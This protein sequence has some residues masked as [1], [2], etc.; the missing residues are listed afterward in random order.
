MVLGDVEETITVVEMDEETYE[1]A[2][3]VILY[4]GIDNRHV[5]TLLLTLFLFFLDRKKANGDALCERRRYYI[6]T[7]NVYLI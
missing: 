4:M 7:S 1:E 3:R 2:V 5:F 6:G